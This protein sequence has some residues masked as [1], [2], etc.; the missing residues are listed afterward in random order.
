MLTGICFVG[1]V[2]PTNADVVICLS[3]ELNGETQDNLTAVFRFD[4]D[5]LNQE[6]FHYFNQRLETVRN[7][8]SGILALPVLG[9]GNDS[10]GIEPVFE[11]STNLDINFEQTEK[12]ASLLSEEWYVSKALAFKFL[13]DPIPTDP[14]EKEEDS[15]RD[16][17]L[18]NPIF[19]VSV[20]ANFLLLALY[21]KKRKP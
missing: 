9:V 8:V 15:W 19:L 3:V 11:N 5:T 10:T 12:C 13:I 4:N 7:Q 20:F 6:F 21:L 17:T 18:E 14:P 16:K 2:Q 1:E